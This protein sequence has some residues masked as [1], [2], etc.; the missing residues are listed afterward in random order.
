MNKIL[1]IIGP[2]A[3]G[4]TDLALNL[5]K[6]FKGE[7]ISC[8]SRQVYI[9]LDIGTGKL[10]AQEVSF[11]KGKGFWEMNGIKVW[12]YDLVY[13]QKQYSVFN[14]L[15]DA[16]QVLENIVK[17]RKLPIIV[18]GTGLYLKALIEGFSNLEIP[19]NYK[20]RAELESKEI[21][22]LQNILKVNYLANWESL[23]NSERNNKRR[24]LRSIELLS[25]NP[26]IQRK[27][28]T[29]SKYKNWNILKIGLYAP[30]PILNKRIDQRLINR[31]DQGLIKEGKML[32]RAG[33]S[34]KRM[35]ELG[36]EYKLLADYFEGKINKEQLVDN[37]K[38]KIHQY[39]KRQMTWFKKDVNINWFDISNDDWIEK[40]E[41]ITL[42]WYNTTN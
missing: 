10:P 23:N 9:G 16:D 27:Q 5:A 14:Y 7:I 17:I 33:L 8:D 12:M 40:V 21:T 26:Y 15:K 42:D 38:I 32:L 6:K 25:M 24:L 41:K 30:R 1:A 19:V 28:I 20:L 4:K 36:L 29:N 35:K 31:F 3:T 11:K 34:F 18:G 37:L 2:T 39:A 13:P 22:E